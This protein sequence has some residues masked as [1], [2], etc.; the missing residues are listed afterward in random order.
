MIVEGIAVSTLVLEIYGLLKIWIP[1]LGGAW[2]IFKVINWVKDIRNKDLI[3]LKCSV[4]ELKV[5]FGTK[6]DSLK[7]E[8]KVQTTEIVGQLKE[9]RSDFRTFY[10]PPQYPHAAQMMPMPALQTS[11]A[12]RA[13]RKAKTVD[14]AAQDLV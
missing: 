4:D 12:K 3:E 10:S 14:K 6:V 11:R 9:M 1:I 5:E 2:G 13:P 8:V 7:E